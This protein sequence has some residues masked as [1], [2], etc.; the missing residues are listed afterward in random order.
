MKKILEYMESLKASILT[1]ISHFQM[2]DYIAYAWLI[3]LFFITLFVAILLAKRRPILAIFILIFDL[4]LLGAGPF[5]VKMVLDSYLRKTLVELT[6]TKQLIYSDTLIIQGNL[7]NQSKTDFASCRVHASIHPKT[8][9]GFMAD[10]KKLK[11]LWQTSIF[12]QEP[13]AIGESKAFE[14][15]W[16]GI[17]LGEDQNLSVKGEC[18]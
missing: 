8:D 11:L 6:T 14:I 17:R 18:Y 15:V 16:E 3:L 2:A 9:A 7:Y 1:Y 10:L 5:G 12:I 13:P 4:A